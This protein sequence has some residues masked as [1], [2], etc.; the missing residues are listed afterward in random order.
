MNLRNQLPPALQRELKVPSSSA[1]E[2]TV[3][4]SVALILFTAF[5]AALLLVLIVMPR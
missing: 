3:G 2:R 4:A 5:A 1:F